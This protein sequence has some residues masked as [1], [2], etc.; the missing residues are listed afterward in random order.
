M[1][2]D[3]EILILSATPDGILDDGEGS[4]EMKCPSS[5]AEV[6]PEIDAILQRN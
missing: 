6:D 5:M 3:N 2:I 4:V 1:F